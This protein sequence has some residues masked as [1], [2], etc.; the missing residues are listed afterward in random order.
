MTTVLLNKL[1]S[2]TA[3][4]AVDLVIVLVSATGCYYDKEEKLYPQTVCDTATVTYSSSVVPILLSN[5][6]VCHG[7]NTP[8]AGIKLDTYAGVKVQADNGKLWGAVS[9]SA[10]FS[11]M[12]KNGTKL[13]ACN[14][15]KIKKWLDAGALNN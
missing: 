15:T 2:I 11:P 8:S 3:L 6:T 1:K 12:P 4:L 7:G 10:G 14:L 5:C 13:S 9:Q